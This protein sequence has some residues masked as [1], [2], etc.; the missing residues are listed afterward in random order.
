ML[1]LSRGSEWIENNKIALVK[2]D[3]IPEDGFSLDYEKEKP[4]YLTLFF[5][6]D[7]NFLSLA[8]KFIQLARQWRYDTEIYSSISKIIS[9]PNYLEIIAMGESAL[10]FI[11]AQMKKDPYHWFVALT[12]ITGE[13]PAKQGCTFDE[14]V[15]AWLDWGEAKGYI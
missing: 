11:F 14:S 5:Q 15:K 7:N 9:H 1:V 6:T 3:S 12:R 8:H 10:P 4:A 13:S 2:D